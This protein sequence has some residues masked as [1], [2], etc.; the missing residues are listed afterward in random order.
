MSFLGRKLKNLLLIFL[1]VIILLFVLTKG[2]E[3]QRINE[4]AS[5]ST[6]RLD[7][8]ERCEIDLYVEDILSLILADSVSS[9]IQNIIDNN[10]EEL[11]P[12]LGYF[13]NVKR[14]LQYGENCNK[15]DGNFALLPN[16]GYRLDYFERRISIKLLEMIVGTC[17]ENFSQK[18]KII[19]DKVRKTFSIR[20]LNTV[21][22]SVCANNNLSTRVD[23]EK[24]YPSV[25]KTK[26]RISKIYPSNSDCNNHNVKPYARKKIPDGL[27]TAH[28]NIIPRSL[29][30]KF[31]DLWVN[32]SITDGRLISANCP[33]K[34]RLKRLLT[35]IL[36]FDF[37]DESLESDEYNLNYNINSYFYHND[38]LLSLLAWNPGGNIF[39]GP[40]QKNRG[41][42]YPLFGLQGEETMNAFEVDVESIIGEEHYREML[43]LYR[44]LIRYVYTDDWDTTPHERFITG[45]ELVISII[46]TLIGRKTTPMNIEQWEEITMTEEQLLKFD[47]AER[48]TFRGKKFWVIKKNHKRYERFAVQKIEKSYSVEQF[49]KNRWSEFIAY[50]MSTFLLS[51]STH[52]S[53]TWSCDFL[54]LYLEYH[55][56]TQF[57]NNSSCENKNFDTYLYLKISFSQ[58][59]SDCI[60][61]NKSKVLAEWCQALKRVMFE[62]NLDCG[63]SM[64]NI[65][66][67]Q[68]YQDL[69]ILMKWLLQNVLFKTRYHVKLYNKYENEY[70]GFITS[71]NNFSQQFFQEVPSTL[72]NLLSTL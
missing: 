45:S 40:S 5:T 42:F 1:I 50:V 65:Q 60:S 66:P 12:S 69:N 55:L 11:L 72:I 41:P 51:Q 23:L 2:N 61:F 49:S 59:W 52:E 46:I 63:N 19:R 70:Y 44:R 15:G 47:E 14:R 37:I 38:V 62:Y 26:Q 36:N 22:S 7:D 21:R 58:K 29:M 48:C 9:D 25:A 30:V 28:Y 32:N 6:E 43:T 18:F 39:L 67:K 71:K 53:E 13:Q 64:E 56:N 16:H 68:F 35:K 31:Y 20:R 8:N 34:A 17:T 27:K 54:R 57:S 33:I 24:M 4:G 10:L 3:D